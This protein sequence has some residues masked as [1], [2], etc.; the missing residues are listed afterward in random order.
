MLPYWTW[1]LLINKRYVYIINNGYYEQQQHD[2]SDE[3]LRDINEDDDE[4][5]DVQVL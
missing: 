2:Y 3:V 1:P 4:G 5:G